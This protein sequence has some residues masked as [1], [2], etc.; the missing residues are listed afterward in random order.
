MRGNRFWM[1]DRHVGNHLLPEREEHEIAAV[2]RPR[3]E[4]R[5]RLGADRRKKK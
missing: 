1:G 5:T 3:L 4:D 2:R